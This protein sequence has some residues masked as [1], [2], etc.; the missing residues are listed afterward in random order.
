M[1]ISVII[2]YKEDRGFLLAAKK[3]ILNQTYK[4]IEVIECKSDASVGANLNAGIEKCTGELVTYL[5]DDDLLPRLALSFYAKYWQ[6]EWDFCHANAINFKSGSICIRKP[7]IINPTLSEMIQCNQIHGG[8]VCYHRR[9]FEAGFRF[10]E[11]L[12][13]A[14]EYDFNLKLLKSGMVL[15]YIDEIVYKYRIHPK[16]KSR[17]LRKTGE[18]R[19]EAINQIRMRYDNS[20]HSNPCG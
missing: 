17:I 1:K 2:P 20:E 4:D 10:D 6:P 14:E 13:T 18:K 8:T 16:Q 7:S 19:L 12:W 5:C 15:G 3:S 11:S 9:I